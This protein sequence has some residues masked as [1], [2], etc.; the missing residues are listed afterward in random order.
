MLSWHQ[1][2]GAKLSLIALV[3]VVLEYDLEEAEGEKGVK[4]WRRHGIKNNRNSFYFFG[5]GNFFIGTF[6]LKIIYPSSYILFVQWSSDSLVE[7][8]HSPRK[9]KTKPCPNCN[10]GKFL[11]LSHYLKTKYFVITKNHYFFILY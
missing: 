10:L 7:Y 3:T 9:T 8:L 1:R 11:F 5:G 2:K 6:F 4:K